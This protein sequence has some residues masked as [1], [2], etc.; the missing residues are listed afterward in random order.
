MEIRLAYYPL[1]RSITTL[2]D[3]VVY[4]KPQLRDSD[5]VSIKIEPAESSR[6]TFLY[7]YSSYF[8]SLLSKDWPC[9]SGLCGNLLQREGRKISVTS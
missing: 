8:V 1:W 3:H 9:L 2:L 7:L 6:K 4:S 5:F